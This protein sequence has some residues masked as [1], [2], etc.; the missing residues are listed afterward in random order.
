MDAYPD[1]M[2]DLKSPTSHVKIK[3]I[4]FIRESFR[5]QEEGEGTCSCEHTIHGPRNTAFVSL[6]QVPK[7]RKEFLEI[8][9]VLEKSSSIQSQQSSPTE[10]KQS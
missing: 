1:S 8:K 4:S 10:T 9:S 5:Q 6:S 7:A 2:L 3:C